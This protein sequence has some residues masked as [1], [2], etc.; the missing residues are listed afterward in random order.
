[1]PSDPRSI[2]VAVAGP[3]SGRAAALGTEM[4]HAA[5]LAVEHRNAAGGIAGVA[6]EALA[7]DD[8][9]DVERG[10]AIAR[11][12]CDDRTVSGVV[13]HYNSDV[14]LAASEVYDASG[15]AMI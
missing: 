14:T 12:L 15:L 3:L 7:C 11:E 4:R 13:G 10:L 6:V 5:Q 2:V 1:M 8:A 9:A